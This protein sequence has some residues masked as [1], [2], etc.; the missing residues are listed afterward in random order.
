MIGC[1][2]GGEG[3]GGG[4]L[5]AVVVAVVRGGARL[6]PL[7][8]NGEDLI[9]VDGGRLDGGGREGSE[10]ELDGVHLGFVCRRK[11]NV[12]FGV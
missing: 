10:G 9:T 3:G 12:Q 2:K 6:L 5:T 1:A 4:G 11:T 7:Q 8:E